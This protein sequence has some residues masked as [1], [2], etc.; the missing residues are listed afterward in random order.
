MAAEPETRTGPRW[1]RVLHAA[2]DALLAAMLGAMILLAT[3]QI[4]LRNLFQSGASWAD[5]L[6]RASVLWLGLLAAASASR[7]N[8]HIVIDVLARLLPRR[9]LPA[10]GVLTQAF[11]AGVSGLIAYHAVRF[12]VS[13]AEAGTEAFAGLPAWVVEAILPAGFGLIALRYAIRAALLLRGLV[14]GRAAP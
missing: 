12:V 11:T 7:E 13:E 10:V 8:R 3:T 6:L 14:A 1:L 4:A 2:E 5:P 9:A